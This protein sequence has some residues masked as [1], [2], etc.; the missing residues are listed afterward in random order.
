MFTAVYERPATSTQ[1]L[2]T[3]PQ[4]NVTVLNQYFG[5]MTGYDWTYQLNELTPRG[6]AQTSSYFEDSMSMAWQQ[7]SERCMAP[8]AWLTILQLYSSTG[9]SRGSTGCSLYNHRTHSCC[10]LACCQLPC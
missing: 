2:L 9:Y 7:C 6:Y 4:A 3:G 5:K 1:G 10:N 8:R